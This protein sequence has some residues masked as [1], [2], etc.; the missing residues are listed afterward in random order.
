MHKAPFHQNG[1]EIGLIGD[2]HCY[3]FYSALLS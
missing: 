1:G 3:V 2:T